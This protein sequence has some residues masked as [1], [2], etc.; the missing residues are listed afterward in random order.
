MSEAQLAEQ[1]TGTESAEV[2]TSPAEQ[3]VEKIDYQKRY[4]DS[5]AEAKRLHEEN[6]AVKA[7]AEALEKQLATKSEPKAQEFQFPSKSEYVR[8]LVE[9]HDKTEK[10]AAWEYDKDLYNFN[11]TRNLIAQNQALSNAIRFKDQQNDRG[12]V[13]LNPSAKEAMEFCKQFPEFDALPLSEKIQRYNTLK[14]LLVPKGN[15]RDLSSVKAGA[16]AGVGSGSGRGE[17]VDNSQNDADARAAGFP[18]HE[19]MMATSRAK[20]AEEFAAVKKKYNLKF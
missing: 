2:I 15:G 12:L 18:S 8:N 5:S 20:T 13:E 11:T 6:I 4:S 10:E 14:P 3:P 9:N 7:K 1:A 19:A 16:S 17:G